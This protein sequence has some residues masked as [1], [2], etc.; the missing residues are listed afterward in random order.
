MEG[1]LLGSFLCMTFLGVPVAF[2]LGLSVSIILFQYLN[3]PQ[4][5]ITQTMYSGVDSF[6]F[7][8]VPFF[9]ACR[10]PSCPRAG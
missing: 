9:N 8:A 4:V 3:M 1:V 7:M 5:M 2:A 6:S 10:G